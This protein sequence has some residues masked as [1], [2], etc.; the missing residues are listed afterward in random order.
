MR[1]RTVMFESW[2]GLYADSPRALSERLATTDP[3]FRRLWVTSGENEFPADVATVQRH[4][5]AYFRSL[6]TTDVLVANDIVSKHLVKG[7]RV[8]YLQMWHGTP[9]KLIGHDERA[10]SYTGAQAHLKRMVRDVAKWDYLVSPSPACSE[11]FR[12]AFGFEGEMWETGYPRNDVLRSPDAAAR[13]TEVRDLLGIP[14]DALAVLHAPTWRDDDKSDEGRFRQSVLLDA[15]L[16]ARAL[17]TGSRLLLR[18]HRNVTERPAATQGDFVVDVSSHPDIAELY[19]AADVLVSDYS[20]AVYDYAVTGKPIVLFA[21]DLDRYRDSVR[22][23]Y[24]DYEDWAPGPVALTQEDLAASLGDLAEVSRAWGERYRAFVQRFCPHEDGRAGERVADRLRSVLSKGSPARGAAHLL[25]QPCVVRLEVALQTCPQLRLH[26]RARPGVPLLD[27]LGLPLGQ[28]QPRAQPVELTARVGEEHVGVDDVDTVG[29]QL[30]D[31]PVDL[32]AVT[33]PGQVG[34]VPV[35]EAPVRRVGHH[36]LRLAGGAFLLQGDGL[37]ELLRLV[38]AGQLVPVGRVRA[39]HR[40]AHHHHDL[41]V[42]Q[43]VG[44]ALGCERVEEVVAAALERRRLGSVSPPGGPPQRE[45]TAVPAWPAFVL[46][47]EVA[48]PLGH[49]RAGDCGVVAQHAVEGRGAGA[50]SADDDERRTQPPARGQPAPQG[51]PRPQEE[52]QPVWCVLAHE[53]RHPAH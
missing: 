7:P 27:L 42:G 43:V 1:S 2:R 39:L 20:S 4:S 52:H 26:R 14:Q 13:R 5:P 18:L 19:L 28:P 36:S 3:S 34:V 23:M 53:A 45:V 15:D 12:S 11:I 35:V 50:L 29:T 32:L 47:V 49:R 6:L 33:A 46:Q 9:L 10:H 51:Q 25:G 30:V 44:D 37:L 24:F 48:D 40:L 38:A 31:E 8:H 22:G 17:P 21:P 41:H 16:L